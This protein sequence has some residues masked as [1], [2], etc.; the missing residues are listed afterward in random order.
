M[1]HRSRI[2]VLDSLVNIRQDVARRRNA[3]STMP[4]MPEVTEAQIE[5]F[6]AA[7]R[8]TI[9]EVPYCWLAT[10]S[11]DG[12]TNARAVNSSPGTPADDAWT[13]RFLVRRGS[14][15]VAEMR[16]APRVTLAYQHA[17]GDAYVALSGRA[18]LVEDRA[19]MRTMWPT[20][21]DARFP[22][23]FADAHMIV[24]R[25]EVDRIEVHERGVTREPFG[26]GRTLIERNGNGG[27]RFVPDY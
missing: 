6:L 3:M 5:R 17:S 1:T 15:K 2:Y 26:H 20:S 14:R 25:V 23:G 11:A 21:M 22:P 24:V 8:E 7:A 19:E 13:R 16:A 4:V 9:N 12:G 10:R 18:T 27:W